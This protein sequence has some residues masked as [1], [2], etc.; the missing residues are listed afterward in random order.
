MGSPLLSSRME[1]TE[2]IDAATTKSSS[3]VAWCESANVT[4]VIAKSAPL[5]LSVFHS[6]SRMETMKRGSA[7]VS[8]VTPP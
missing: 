6:R 5:L 7:Y 4:E 2:M 8:L 3:A 1:S